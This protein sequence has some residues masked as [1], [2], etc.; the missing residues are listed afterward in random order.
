VKFWQALIYVP[1]D[2]L[3]ELARLA[4]D[5]GFEGVLLP[6]HVVFPENAESRYP[7]ADVPYNPK[8]PFADC[9]AAIGA[10]AA[11]TSRLRFATYVYVVP[12]RDPYSVAK[13]F[14]TLAI[15]SGGRVALGAGVGWLA[16]EYA[17][18]ESDFGTRGRRMDES[19]AAIGAL[20]RDGRH[21]D[22][23]AGPVHMRPV[24]PQPVPIWSVATATLRCDGRPARTAGWACATGWR[25]SPNTWPASTLRSV[26]RAATAPGSRSWPCPTPR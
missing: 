18:L 12:M 11:A 24:P 14:G 1:T 9:V 13:A 20:L 25:S 23:V 21:D 26:P 15:L 2:E 7:Y 19:L 17:T 4:E 16:E 10:M 6:D 22:P 3:V 8:A 5:V